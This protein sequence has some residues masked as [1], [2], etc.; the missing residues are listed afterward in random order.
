M[1]LHRP[2]KVLWACH[3]QE[4]IALVHDTQRLFFVTEIAQSQIESQTLIQRALQGHNNP[5]KADIL[6]REAHGFHGGIG[7]TEFDG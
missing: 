7:G 5:L 1:G 3:G 4:A 2:C 6:G